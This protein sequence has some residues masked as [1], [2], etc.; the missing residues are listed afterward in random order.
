MEPSPGVSEEDDF[1][2][3]DLLDLHFGEYESEAER[4]VREA[5][6]AHLK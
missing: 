3:L 6:E 5:R 4:L 2:D 1:A